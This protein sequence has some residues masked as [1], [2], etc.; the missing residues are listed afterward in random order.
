MLVNKDTIK[1]INAAKTLIK[2]CARYKNCDNCVFCKSDAGS[3][4][5]GCCAVNF[6]YEYRE[7]DK[8]G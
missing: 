5:V 2:Y 1:A 6:P 8:E 4:T 3:I 7:I